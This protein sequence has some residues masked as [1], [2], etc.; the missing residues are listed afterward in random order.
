[1][2]SRLDRLEGV[3]E[4]LRPAVTE[5]FRLCQSKLKRTLL[6]VHGYRSAQEQLLAYQKGRTFDRELADWVVSDKKLIVTNARP[7]QSVHNVIKK[8]DGTAAA[9]GID[10]APFLSDGG[11]NWSPGETFW[12]E[13]SEIAWDVGLDPYHDMIGAYFPGD[14][15]HFEEPGWKLKLEGLGLILPTSNL[16]REV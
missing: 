8:L 16:V 11:I 14:D 3:A 5:L 2:N 13:L 15:G 4:F 12:N 6:L 9:L 10:A 7:G 1:M